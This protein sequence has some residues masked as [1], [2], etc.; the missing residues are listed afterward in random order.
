MLRHAFL[1]LGLGFLPPLFSLLAGLRCFFLKEYLKD[2]TK[3][4]A[5]AL[6]VLVYVEARHNCSAYVNVPNIYTGTRQSSNT[7][8]TL[9]PVSSV[10]GLQHSQGSCL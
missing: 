4:M 9:M 7:S 10:E 2:G 3:S 1:F 5:T 6:H 8:T